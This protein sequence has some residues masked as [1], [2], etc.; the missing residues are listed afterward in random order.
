MPPSK[1]QFFDKP[2]TVFGQRL[3]GFGYPFGFC[4]F[5]PRLVTIVFRSH[6]WGRATWQDDESQRCAQNSHAEAY[7]CSPIQSDRSSPR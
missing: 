5:S 6:P 4:Y 2:F 1:A 7:P 3:K